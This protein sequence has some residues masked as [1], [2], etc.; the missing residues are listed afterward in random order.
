M[1]ET[2][3]KSKYADFNYA[4]LSKLINDAYANDPDRRAW[5]TRL[6]GDTGGLLLDA[7]THS[8]HCF[9]DP[10]VDMIVLRLY[11]QRG[12]AYVNDIRAMIRVNRALMSMQRLATQ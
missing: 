12:M 1:K 5:G 7:R 3:R 2:L 8:V 10:I 6:V 4:E 11:S 9:R